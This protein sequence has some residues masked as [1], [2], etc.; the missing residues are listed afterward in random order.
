MREYNKSEK[1][2][3]VKKDKKI[4][5]KCYQKLGNRTV[6]GERLEQVKYLYHVR[7]KHRKKKTTEGLE[8]LIKVSKIH[9]DK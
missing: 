2:K 1:I 8:N 3:M 6:E 7:W 5:Y 9:K 4:K